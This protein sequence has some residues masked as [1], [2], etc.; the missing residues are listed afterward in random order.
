[1]PEKVVFTGTPVRSEFMDMSKEEAKEKLGL[2]GKKLVVS[3][4]GSLGAEVMN[5][6]MADFI[7][8]NSVKGG[9]HHIHAT[10]GGEEGLKKMKEE[11]ARRGVT[12]KQLSNTDLRMYIDNMPT[13]MTAADIVLCRSGASTI[14]ELTAIGKPSILVPSPYV[15]DNHQEKNAKSVE[16]I[17]GAVMIREGECTG[18]LLYSRVSEILKDAGR[19]DSMSRAV[20]QMGVPDS[21]ERIAKEILNFSR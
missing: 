18:E 21:A 6:I 4:W 17:G 7:E 14:G 9:F 8:I 11:L 5:G 10:G 16:D 20:R 12:Q 13:V 1:M 2:T 15:V 19:L 3:F